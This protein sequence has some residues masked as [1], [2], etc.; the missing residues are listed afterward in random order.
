[1]DTVIDA[2]GKFL[3]PGLWDMHSH[4]QKSDGVWYLAG[5]VT[6]VRDMGNAAILLSYKKQIA[7][8]QLLGPDISYASGF[9][10]KKGPYQGPT[11]N[12]VSTKEE[13]IETIN[14]L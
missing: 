7:S 5:G 10:D 1:A 4:Y 14:A 6:H 8:N 3:I 12:I 9:I 2:N 13:A 11:G